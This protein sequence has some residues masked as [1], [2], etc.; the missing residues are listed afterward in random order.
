MPV[1]DPAITAVLKAEH[2]SE[3]TR[4]VYS[5]KLAIIA[6][7]AG[8]RPLLK[9]L[10]QHADK[11]VKYITE[12]YSEVASQKNMI[13][14]VMAVYRL[15]DLKTKAQVSYDLYLK[16]FDKLK[17]I[18]RERSKTNLP[19]QRQA[20]GFVTHEE[21]QQVRKRLPVGSKERLLLSFYGGCIPPV[22]NDLHAAFIHLLKCNEGEARA[23]FLYLGL[24]SSD[25]SLPRAPTVDSSALLGSAQ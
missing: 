5:S 10:T 15:L 22:R 8:G 7:A 17:A 16:L 24:Q 2:L 6:Q 12:Q 21:L 3:E 23:A 25:V 11:V 4:R 13:V 20:A 1:V 14:S 18:L 9:L 19:S